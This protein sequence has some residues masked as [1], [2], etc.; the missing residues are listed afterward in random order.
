[1]RCPPATAPPRPPRRWPA[2]PPVCAP[3][4]RPCPLLPRPP[5]RADLTTISRRLAPRRLREERLVLVLDVGAQGAPVGARAGRP[6]VAVL[7]VKEVVARQPADARAGRRHADP[8]LV[9]LPPRHRFVV[10]A[11]LRPVAPAEGCC[12][13]DRVLG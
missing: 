6:R 7:A 8:E 12:A 2:K 10:A 3:F 4:W 1:R 9:V 11:D 5:P 13:V